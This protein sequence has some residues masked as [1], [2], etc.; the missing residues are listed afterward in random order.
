ML[1]F[2]KKQAKNLT[3][4]STKFADSC[5]KTITTNIT[6]HAH[7]LQN[8]YYEYRSL[9]KKNTD[10]NH[11]IF[12]ES[13]SKAEL[14]FESIKAWINLFS[15]DRPNF[16]RYKSNSDTFDQIAL[17][18]ICS[19]N[20]LRLDQLTEAD[21]SNIK[22]TAKNLL[23]SKEK[24]ILQSQL[25]TVKEYIN[26]HIN[27]IQVEAIKYKLNNYYDADDKE[28]L[29]LQIIKILKNTNDYD[30]IAISEKLS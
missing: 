24:S 1:N 18:L 25:E 9:T 20:N 5:Y 7:K 29:Y 10:D 19:E 4:Q 14:R 28:F 15:V 16:F 23:K 22:M 2:L 17:D 8:K 13:K 12:G 6:K 11:L 30:N 27:D 3:K 26:N 21:I